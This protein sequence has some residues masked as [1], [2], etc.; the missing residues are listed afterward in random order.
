LNELAHVC[1]FRRVDSA[2]S[3]EWRCAGLL[4][5]SG[6]NSHASSNIHS[7]D[8]GGVVEPLP[9]L[10]PLDNSIPS[11]SSMI[12]SLVFIKREPLKTR[13]EHGQIEGDIAP[14][15]VYA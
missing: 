8:S 14:A 7:A 13:R 3:S 12:A 6:P 9:P 1:A 5:A 4:N 15:P 2:Q 11:I 10:P